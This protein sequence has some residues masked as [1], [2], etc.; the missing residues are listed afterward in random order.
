MG[1]LLR[2]INRMEC[3]LDFDMGLERFSISTRVKDFVKYYFTRFF[4]NISHAFKDFSRS[5]LVDFDKRYQLQ[6][7]QTLKN[8]LIHLKDTIVPIPKG[9]I[10][11]YLETLETLV[12]VLGTI[13]PGSLEDDLRS[14]ETALEK[15]DPSLLY[16][17]K[18]SK[19]DFEKS[20]KII[21][22]LYT[23]NGL[24]HVTASSALVSLEET[25]RVRS[26]LSSLTI[27]YYPEVLTL[28][29]TIKSLENIHS[30]VTIDP[31]DTEKYGTVLMEAAYRMS[32][33]A[34]VMDCIQDMEH[35]FVKALT[36]LKDVSSKT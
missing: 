20:K 23:K 17:P 21:G 24:T 10:N 26:L 7:D 27:E 2:D 1:N 29:T 13:S 8:P 12:S 30:S 15:N 35:A 34:I 14:V 18:Y 22:S 16:S 9:M 6:L 19:K 25:I 31:Q 5:E 32:I 11:P 3:I 33:F 36:V 4:T 28:L